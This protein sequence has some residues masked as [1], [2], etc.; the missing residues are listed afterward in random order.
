MKK[1]DVVI[2]FSFNNRNLNQKN[3]HSCDICALHLITSAGVIH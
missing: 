1:L 2:L 3:L